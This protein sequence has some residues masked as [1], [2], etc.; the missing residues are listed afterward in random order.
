MYCENSLD[1]RLWVRSEEIGELYIDIY[2]PP[3][4]YSL[5]YKKSDGGQTYPDQYRILAYLYATNGDRAGN[6]QAVRYIGVAGGFKFRVNFAY[7]SCQLPNGQWRTNDNAKAKY[8]C[9]WTLEIF[10]GGWT[11]RHGQYHPKGVWHYLTNQTYGTTD[12]SCSHILNYPKYSHYEIEEIE[13]PKD[14]WEL[15]VWDHENNEI[16]K[17]YF[18]EKPTCKPQC[19]KCP[20]GQIICNGSCVCDP[21]IIKPPANHA[22]STAESIT[23]KIKQILKD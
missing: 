8:A 2:N 20:P 10:C 22:A 18:A 3:F 12:R 1:A 4:D 19:N 5:T 9:I 7:Y 6:S 13:G 15:K 23:N 14:G 21:A 11:G 17:H 16:Y